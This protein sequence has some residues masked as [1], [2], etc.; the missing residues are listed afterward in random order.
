MK[1]KDPKNRSTIVRVGW[2][3]NTNFKIWALKDIK[4]YMVYA[5]FKLF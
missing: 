5:G 4:I 1:G 2:I 3:K